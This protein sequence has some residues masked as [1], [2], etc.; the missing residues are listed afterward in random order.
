MH[1]TFIAVRLGVGQVGEERSLLGGT[2]DEAGVRGG[3]D[4]CAVGLCGVEG[5]L[6]S[7]WMCSSNFFPSPLTVLARPMTC[8]SNLSV[9]LDSGFVEPKVSAAGASS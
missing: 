8:S 5:I 9:S 2:L 3:F 6:S 7:V 1:C 4:R